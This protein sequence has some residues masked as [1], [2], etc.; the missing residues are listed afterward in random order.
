MTTSF[1]IA[2]TMIVVAIVLA[3]CTSSD[4]LSG[5]A[6][7]SLYQRWTLIHTSGGFGGTVIEYP[8]RN[9]S[10]WLTADGNA[11][12]YD[13]GSIVSRTS[14]TLNYGPSVITSDSVQLVRYANEPVTRIIAR[15]TRDT[16]MLIDNAYDG[17]THIYERG[18]QNT[19]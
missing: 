3:A 7:T 5:P 10:L 17:M 13:G 14:F 15:L 12:T 6:S 8:D 2:R 19:R 4:D 1:L 9:L 16:L 18:S 11:T